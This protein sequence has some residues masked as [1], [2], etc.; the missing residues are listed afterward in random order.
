MRLSLICLGIV[1]I[2]KKHLNYVLYNIYLLWIVKLALVIYSML[3]FVKQLLTISAQALK[4]L[5]IN[6]CRKIA[7][8]NASEPFEAMHN[9]DGDHIIDVGASMNPSDQVRASSDFCSN[10]CTL[11]DNV[12]NFI[13]SCHA[14]TKNYTAEMYGNSIIFYT[15]SCLIFFSVATFA[16]SHCYK[17]N[18]HQK[19]WK[20]F[21]SWVISVIQ[22][23]RLKSKVFIPERYENN[24]FVS[25][26]ISYSFF[27]YLMLLYS[28]GSITFH[29]INIM[30]LFYLLT[31]YLVVLVLSCFGT[32]VN[33]LVHY[34]NTYIGY[35]YNLVLYV[36]SL[37]MTYPT[38]LLSDYMSLYLGSTNLMTK[39]KDLVASEVDK[40]AYNS[41]RLFKHLS[42][43]K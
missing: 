37:V 7:L 3:I 5:G 36:V 42:A 28:V 39:L 25:N 21:K 24:T 9:F 41:K 38:D 30:F 16:V 22:E 33:Y 13:H 27:F 43:A 17:Y 29:F 40:K 10:L 32:Y 35:V 14:Y 34:S 26:L 11:K 31:L 18:T 23:S 1:S 8:M 6:L 2:P 4:I 15:M 12:F 20:K 19:L